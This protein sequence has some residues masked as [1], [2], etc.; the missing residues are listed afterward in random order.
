[1][2][3]AGRLMARLDFALEERT[4]ELLDHAVDLLDQVSGER[5]MNELELVFRERQPERALQQLDDLGIL[6]AIHPGLMVDKWLIKQL[7]LLCAGLD[8]TPWCDVTPD[9]VHYLGLM[10]FSLAQDELDVLIERLNLRT[11][12][13]ATLRQVYTIKRKANQIVKAERGSKLYH[14]LQP[15][16]DDAQLIAWLAL[17]NE[18][19]RRQIIHFQTE[20]RNVNPMIDGHYLQREMRLHP[21]PLFKYILETLR[22]ARLD[23]LVSSVTRTYTGRRSITRAANGASIIESGHTGKHLEAVHSLRPL[24]ITAY[25]WTN[26]TS[27]ARSSSILTPNWLIIRRFSSVV[28]PTSQ[29]I[30]T[31]SLNSLISSMLSGISL[32]WLIFSCRSPTDCMALSISWSSTILRLTLE[33]LLAFALY[34]A[35]PCSL[36]GRYSHDY[37]ASSVA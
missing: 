37:Y 31:I 28:N 21:G 15:V 16:S 8:E 3:R 33:N 14:L 10:T 36:V 1:M 19:A 22:N 18:P 13:R 2:L 11:N 26:E 4:A 5:V 29:L 35:F 17:D 32:I 30:S 34:P 9:T 7:G 27:P 23:G 12:Q 6:A 25:I 24:P 20:L